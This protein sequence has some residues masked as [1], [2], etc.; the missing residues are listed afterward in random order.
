MLPGLRQPFQNS[1]SASINRQSHNASNRCKLWAAA[2]GQTGED[3]TGNKAETE[4]T[5]EDPAYR[6]FLEYLAGGV[7]SE[8]GDLPLEHLRREGELGWG[9]DTEGPLGPEKVDN[10]YHK[11][12]KSLEAEMN[13]RIGQRHLGKDGVYTQYF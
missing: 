8:F 2:T 13:S 10:V 9:F 5:D 1:G 4:D 7:D 11:V 3:R 12:S 6:A